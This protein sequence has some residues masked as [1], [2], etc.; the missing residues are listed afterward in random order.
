MDINYKEIAAYAVAFA[1]KNQINLDFSEESI[2]K[3]DSILDYYYQNLD[4]FDSTQEEDTLWNIAV[5]FGIYLGETMLNLQLRNQGFEWIVS[6]EIPI[7]RNEKKFEISPVTKAHKRILYGP[8]DS[9][10]SF[11]SVVFSIADGDFPTKQVLR[12]VDAETASGQ[13]IPNVLYQEIDSYIMDVETGKEDFLILSSHDGFL[14]FYGINNRFIAE[15]RVNLP[16]NDFRVFS[17]INKEKEHLTQR[18]TLTTPYGQFTPTEREVIS[19]D[20]IQ[21]AVRSYY[22]HHDTD[23]F[24]KDIPYVEVTEEHKRCMGLIE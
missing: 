21:S 4:K 11:C 9:I 6:E 20:S 15:V 17:I 12:V 16:D 2:E 1:K 14:Q 19:L 13:M 5:H 18:I 24:L 23:D 3:V 10:K 7:L 22:N 8:D